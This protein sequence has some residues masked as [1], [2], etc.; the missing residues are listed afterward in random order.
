MMRELTQSRP[1]D[2][3]R[4][5]SCSCFASSRVLPSSK[6]VFLESGSG[7]LAHL[8]DGLERSSTVSSSESSTSASSGGK[9]L[10]RWRDGV[11]GVTNLEGL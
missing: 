5:S 2:K 3:S 9:G 8:V 4:R 6:A 11:F 10:G 7:F 1:R